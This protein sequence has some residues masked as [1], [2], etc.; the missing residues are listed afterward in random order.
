MIPDINVLFVAITNILLAGRMRHLTDVKNMTTT[1]L[2]LTV[3]AAV[4]KKHYCVRKSVL[5]VEFMKC[6]RMFEVCFE[7]KFEAL[8]LWIFSWY[9]DRNL[10]CLPADSHFQIFHG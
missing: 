1:I 10:A 8:L 3:N 9:V 5:H 6:Y 4:C 7:L 2:H